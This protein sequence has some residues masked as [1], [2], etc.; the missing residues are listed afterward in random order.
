ML[1]TV[2]EEEQKWFH[3]NKPTR[4]RKKSE[5]LVMKIK[6]ETEH[7]EDAVIFC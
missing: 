2:L 4:F 5:R 3:N 1:L 7:F 6:M